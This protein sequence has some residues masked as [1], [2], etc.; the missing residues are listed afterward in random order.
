LDKETEPTKILSAVIDGQDH[1]IYMVDRTFD[2]WA[3]VSEREL[4]PNE[5]VHFWGSPGHNSDVYRSGYF[6]ES[7]SVKEI[8][9]TLTFKFQQFILPTFGGDSGSGI[10]DESGSIV[11][12]VSMGDT[13]ADNLDLPLAFSQ[14]Q[15]NLAAENK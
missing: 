6:Q 9:A 7:L 10:Y 15:L 12:V 4:I 3:G 13:S 5:P 14:A 11:A 1:V 2:K 8:D